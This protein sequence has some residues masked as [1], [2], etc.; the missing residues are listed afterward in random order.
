MIRARASARLR[1]NRSSISVSQRLEIITR[2]LVD[3]GILM[4]GTRFINPALNANHV[5]DQRK[6]GTNA[7]NSLTRPRRKFPILFSNLF[8]FFWLECPASA[9]EQPLLSEQLPQILKHFFFVRARAISE[10][11]LL[12]RIQCF[13]L[14][15]RGIKPVPYRT[16]ELISVHLT[17][18][19][20]PCVI[21]QSR[22]EVS[23]SRICLERPQL[24]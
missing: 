20:V 16:Q 5:A 19:R 22:I 1:T 14:H 4:M 6:S 21:S 10:K 18:S 17:F 23:D 13:F 9:P 15:R 7:R 12:A 11:E 3:S 2:I 24:V 8:C